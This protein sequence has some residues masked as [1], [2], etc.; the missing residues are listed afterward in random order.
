MTR[1]EK[2]LAMCVGGT[3]GG[4]A[5]VGLVRWAV[6]DPFRSVQRQIEEEQARGRRLSAQLRQLAGVEKQWQTWTART[7]GQAEGEAQ[8]RFRKDMQHLLERQGL[9]VQNISPGTP[10]RYKNDFIGVPLTISATGTLNEVVG[11]LCDFYQ[12]D[13]LARLDKVRITADQSVI[14]GLASSRQRPGSGWSSRGSGP[15]STRTAEF[16]PEGPELKVSISAVTLVLPEIRDVEH[17]LMVDII[18]SERRVLRD[19]EEYNVVFDKSVFVPHREKPIVVA[20]SMAPT[21]QRA[22]P[23]PTPIPPVP[24]RPDADRLFVCGTTRLNGELVAYVVDDRRPDQ[25]PTKYHLD[26]PID[27]GKLLLVHPRGLVVRV[28]R[29]DG[30]RTD[31]FYR[32]GKSFRD[33]EELS[34]QDHPEVWEA[35]ELELKPWGA[36]AADGAAGARRLSAGPQGG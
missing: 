4:L 29:T 15:G 11:F 23:E 27:D 19:R 22:T 34:P 32:L 30:G 17:P 8:L 33:R 16:G 10:A 7:L 14:A 6:L 12:R 26:D 2:V 36:E 5:L 31:Y 25:K 35:L 18:D 9:R 21:T 24:V 1:R 28:Q 20:T 13:Y 3:L